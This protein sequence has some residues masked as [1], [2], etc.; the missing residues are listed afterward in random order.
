MIK[1]CSLLISSSVIGTYFLLKI[2]REKSLL[3]TFLTFVELKCNF[4]MNITILFISVQDRDSQF[5]LE[6]A[7]RQ[8]I[9]S[10]FLMKI[11]SANASLI[12][13]VGVHTAYLEFILLSVRHKISN[14]GGGNIFLSI[15]RQVK[16]VCTQ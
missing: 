2:L 5:R 11:C 10:T 14:F 9:I 16:Q 3:L 6:F 4:Q 7:W 13:H 8:F 15:T 12:T 1:Y